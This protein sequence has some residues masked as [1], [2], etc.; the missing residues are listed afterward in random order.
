MTG[1][2]IILLGL[3]IGSFLNVCIFRFPRG[4]SIVYTPSHCPS[5]GMRL[6][7]FDLVPVLNYLFLKGRCRYC[8][9]K[10][11]L[12]YPFIELLT[13]AVFCITY[14]NMGLSI[15]LVKYLFFFFSLII[16][17]FID[18][19]HEIIP[20]E[21]VMLILF[22][23]FIWQLVR[24]EISFF[25][26]LGGSLIGGGT[27]LFIALL[28]RGGLGG[29]DIK[30]MFAAGLYL[31]PVMTGLALFISFLSGAVT[32]ILLILFKIKKRREFIPFG[33][34]LSLGIFIAVL[35]GLNM[36]N[37]YMRLTGLL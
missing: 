23:G 28:S 21:L 33:P 8:N 2:V 11:S 5:C 13:A 3:V 7:V 29:G 32:G 27:L 16:I 24:P 17:I 14:L 18:L 35:W 37:G 12:R 31:G 10:I 4:E 26:A 20:N 34:F 6:N 1:I 9:I 22:W 30:L 36:V 15:Y 19:D 25:E